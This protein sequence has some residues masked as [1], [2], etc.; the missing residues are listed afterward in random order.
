LGNVEKKQ[1][2]DESGTIDGEDDES[3]FSSNVKDWEKYWRSLFK[4][5]S[6]EDIDSFF[7]TYKDSAEERIDLLKFYDKHKGD[8]DLIMQEVF[9]EDLVEDEERFRE[10]LND[11][12]EKGECKSYAKFTNES[13]KKASKRKANYEKEAKE[14]EEMRKELGIDE[15]QDSLR[16]MI[17]SRRQVATDDL[18]DRLA[19]KYGGD[20]GSKKPAAAASTKGA[21]KGKKAPE[22]SA[23]NQENE[24]D[25]EFEEEEKEAEE[26]VKGKKKTAAPKAARLSGGK[27]AAA[28]KVKRL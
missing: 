26:V 12:I 18:I 23:S 4:K 8:M 7:K 13:K 22:E 3:I 16:K 15:S 6:K 9:S 2:Y 10:I 5:I 20:K 17:L 14:A 19:Q 11:A 24:S 21:K 1:L 27:T 28:K 25:G